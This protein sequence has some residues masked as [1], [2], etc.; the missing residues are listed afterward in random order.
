MSYDDKVYFW[1]IL[2]EKFVVGCPW[3]WQL[4]PDQT[5]AAQRARWSN[6]W[7]HYDIKH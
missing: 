1:F 5:S 7:N 3:M 4:W 2:E 6:Y